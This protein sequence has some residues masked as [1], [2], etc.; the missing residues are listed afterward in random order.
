MKMIKKGFVLLLALTTMLLMSQAAFAVS[1]TVDGGTYKYDGNKMTDKAGKDIDKAISGLEPG[2]DLTIEL[3]YT[4][5]SEH[6]T[7]WYMENE[8]LRT[9]EET[10]E[11]AE[12]GGY[13]YKLTNIGPDGDETTIFN[14]DAVGGTEAPDGSEEGLKV[15]TDATKDWFFIQEL[16]AGESGNTRLEVA[17][18]GESQINGYMNTNGELEINYAVEDQPETEPPAPG[19]KTGDAFNPLLALAALT[20]AA[21]AMLLAILSYRRDRK[22]GDVA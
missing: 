9:L 4:N 20:A 17:L 10:A 5:D 19:P 15:A 1:T 6:T 3:T 16:A 8:V 18:D 7:Y 11:A 21:L 12:N 13:S 22:D 14:S 2:D